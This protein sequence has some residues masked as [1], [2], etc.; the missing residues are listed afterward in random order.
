[1]QLKFGQKTKE[2]KMLKKILESNKKVRDIVLHEME[3]KDL[4]DLE[5]LTPEDVKEAEKI[6]KI[7]NNAWDKLGIHSGSALYDSEELKTKYLEELKKNLKKKVP[8]KFYVWFEDNNYHAL[9]DALNK[10]DMFEPKLEMQLI[11]FK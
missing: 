7:D 8:A 2:I 1:M 6:M 10:L 11:H 5:E 4:P 9:N 3:Y